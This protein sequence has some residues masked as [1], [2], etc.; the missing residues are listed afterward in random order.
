MNRF[1]AIASFFCTILLCGCGVSDF[2]PC[3]RSGRPFQLISESPSR[4]YSVH[5]Q[6]KCESGYDYWI[7]AKISEGGQLFAEEPRFAVRSYDDG[8]PFDSQFRYFGWA[9]ES[10]FRAGY[11]ESNSA[12]NNETVLVRNDSD[13]V[14]SEIVV[15]G[16]GE[17]LLVLDIQ[18]KSSVTLL[19]KHHIDVDANAIWVAGGQFQD[20]Q[21][22]S[23]TYQRFKE[24]NEATLKFCIE[25]T[26]S[27]VVI[28]YKPSC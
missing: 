9:A 13:K 1:I 16:Y 24:N 26:D 6:E 14:L 23:E 18:P 19:R 5:L 12:A 15:G 2:Y 21:R 27:N 17:L 20:G 22:L 7:G 28:G 8:R 11:N 25:V 10:V 4:T 3:S